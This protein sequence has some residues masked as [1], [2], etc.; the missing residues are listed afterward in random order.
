MLRSRLLFPPLTFPPLPEEY[1]CFFSPSR[2]MAS[3]SLCF[4]SFHSARYDVPRGMMLALTF[5]EDHDE[6]DVLSLLVF[7]SK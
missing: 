4:R 2:S 3:S 6:N 5:V 7:P 1:M